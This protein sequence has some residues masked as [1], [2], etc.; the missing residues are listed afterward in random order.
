MIVFEREKK[1]RE[2][3]S[4][5]PYRSVCKVKFK[6]IMYC[7]TMR[8][9]KCIEYQVYRILELNKDVKEAQKRVKREKI[10]RCS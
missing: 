7:C 3:C 4:E 5:C 9:L 1:I 8:Y 6:N 10:E 2:N